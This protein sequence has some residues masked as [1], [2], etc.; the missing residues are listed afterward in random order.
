VSAYV[1]LNGRSGRFYIEEQ[2]NLA[3]L[4]ESFMPKNWILPFDDE[5]S[6]L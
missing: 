1:T 5:I 2:T 4:K 6:G 3:P